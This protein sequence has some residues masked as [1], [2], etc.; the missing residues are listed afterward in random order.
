MKV[1]ITHP[2]GDA[3]GTARFRTPTRRLAETAGA[4]LPAMLTVLVS[5]MAVTMMLQSLVHGWIGWPAFDYRAFAAAGRAFIEHGAVGAYDLPTL[6]RVGRELVGSDDAT[7]PVAPYPPAFL[8]LLAPF[9][10]LPFIQGFFVWFLINLAGALYSL[11]SLAARFTSHRRKMVLLSVL[12]LPVLDG[13]LVGQPI[14]L[15]L[16]GMSGLYR[17]LESGRDGRAGLWGGLLLF[18]PQYVVLLTLVLALKRRWRVLGG[19]AISGA[20]LALMSVLAAGLDGVRAYLHLLGGTGAIDSDVLG[21]NPEAM[22]TWRGLVVHLAP[23]AP[24]IVAGGVVVLLTALT[25]V[26]MVP[27]WRGA[28][29]P[30]SPRFAL[31]MLATTAAGLLVSYH[32]HTHGAALLVVPLLAAAASGVLPRSAQV[33]VILGLLVSSALV[34]LLAWQEIVWRPAVAV[35]FVAVCGG[36]LMVGLSAFRRSSPERRTALAVPRREARVSSEAGPS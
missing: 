22:M 11:H 9:G 26:A 4:L 13:L 25:A 3:E 28:W 23:D 27:V 10:L 30:G 21:I 35:L 31:Q 34:I 1:T 33:L 36:L 8:L 20:G 24:D 17:S 14:A 18:K 15:L 29:L 32:S 2:E 16:L 19:F 5:I 12:S 7:I 6:T